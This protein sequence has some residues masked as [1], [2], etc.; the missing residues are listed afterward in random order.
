[1][2]CL[3]VVSD[4]RRPVDDALVIRLR[5][6]PAPPLRSSGDSGVLG[7]GDATGPLPLNAR[8]TTDRS[9]PDVRVWLLPGWLHCP[10][11]ADGP[12]LRRPGAP[13]PAVGAVQALYVQRCQCDQEPGTPA[14]SSLERR[15]TE[16]FSARSGPS[17]RELNERPARFALRRRVFLDLLSHKRGDLLSTAWEEAVESYRPY[18]P[19]PQEGVTCVNAISGRLPSSGWGGR[20]SRGLWMRRWR[21][22][23]EPWGGAW[24][25]LWD[26][27]GR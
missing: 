3:V 27:L 22:S 14:A 23:L 10:R 11:E 13:G 7:G 17:T 20:V 21:L 12:S 6:W 15:G 4:G 24:A 18:R 16:D 9:G 19:L 25:A 8:R 5:A 26:G 2:V 1:M